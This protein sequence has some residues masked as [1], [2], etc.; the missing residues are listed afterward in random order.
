[1]KLNEEEILRKKA[2]EE[3]RSIAGELMEV[4]KGKIGCLKD[5]QVYCCVLQLSLF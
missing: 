3:Q 5:S 4:Q 1:M 2:E